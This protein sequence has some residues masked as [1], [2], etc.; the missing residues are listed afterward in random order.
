MFKPLEDVRILDLSRLLPGPFCSQMLVDLG[1]DVIKVEEPGMGDYARWLPPLHGNQGW[2]F[3][4]IN[5]GKRSIRLDLKSPEGRDIFLG[6]ARKA[7][8]VLESFRPRVLSRLGVGYEH[9]R[10]VNPRIIYCSITGHGQDGPLADR[11][12]H[13][14]NYMA[15]CGALDLIGVPD[16]PPVVPGVQMADLAGGALYATLSILAALRQ[17]DKCGEGCLVDVSMSDGVQSLLP[18]ALSQHLG[19]EEPT[20]GR[21]RLAGELACYEVYR[22]S[23]GAYMSLAALEPKFFQ[24]FCRAVGREDL[25]ALHMGG[26]EQQGRL[27]DE[28][29]RLFATRTRQEWGELLEGVDACC[30]PVLTVAEALASPHVKQRKMVSEGE[31]AVRPSFA[32]RFDGERPG[33]DRRTPGFGEHTEQVLEELGIGPE[34]IASLRSNRVI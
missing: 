8:V 2:L 5:R 29:G 3:E 16:G 34:Q 21:M 24:R 6:L 7:D 1:A 19:G 33:T 15:L 30:E 17:R 23:D 9:A 13:D 27:R 20:R 4:L 32:V 28:L 11:V 12:G 25:L 22:A 31:E 14:L 26:K 18:I 10:E